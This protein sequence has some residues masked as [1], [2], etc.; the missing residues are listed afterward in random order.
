MVYLS[1]TQAEHAKMRPW[2][3]IGNT[4]SELRDDFMFVDGRMEWTRA[5]PYNEGLLKIMNEAIDNAIDNTMVSDNPT[6]VI[7]VK[8]TATHF[9]VENNG[10][11]IPCTP[12][13]GREGKLIPEVIFGECLAGSHFDDERNSIGANGLGI[14]QASIF[15]DEF[16]VVCYDPTLKKLFQCTWVDGMDSIARRTLTSCGRPPA[17]TTVVTFKPT[18]RRFNEAGAAVSLTSL[19][20]LLP[21]VF[22]R[23]AQVASTHPNSK[24]QLYFNGGTVL[25]CRDFKSYMKLFPCKH[26]FY[27]RPDPAVPFEYGISLSSTGQFEHQS[28]VNCQRTT[29]DSSSQTKFVTNKVVGV[30]RDYLLAKHKGSVL[31]RATVMSRLSVFVNCRVQNARFSSQTKVELITKVNFGVDIDP[32][33]VLGVLKKS[34]LLAELEKLLHAK[35]AKE[36]GAAMNGSKRADVS[37]V[38]KYDGAIAAGSARSKSCTLFIVEG[39]SA[40]TMVTTGMSVIG[41]TLYGVF[42]IRGKLLNVRGASDAALKGNVEVVAI[43]K[44]LGLRFDCT[45]ATETEFRTLRYGTL[46]ILTDADADG[47]HITGLLINFILY[48]WPALASKG[49]LE[50]FVTPV[51]KVTKGTAHEHFFNE[52]EYLAWRARTADQA[53]WFVQHL[54]GLGTSE[55]A[56]TL[57]YFKDLPRHTKQFVFSTETT[58]LTD[59]IFN[60]KKAVW[61]KE[62]LSGEPERRALDYSAAS[63]PVDEFYNAELYTYSRMDID[64]SIPCVVDGLKKS[65]RQALCGALHH[66]ERTG[67]TIFKVAQL[68]G[69]AAAHT[70]YAHGEISLQDTLV[71]MAQGFC[72]SNNLALLTPKGAFGSRMLNGK[73]A[74]AARY[75]F[76]SL[77]PA[78]RKL[79]HPADDAVLDLLVEEGQTVQPRFYVPTVPLLLL[80]GAHGIGTGFSSKLPCFKLQDVIRLVRASL[81][82]ANDTEPMPWYTGYDANEL[83]ESDPSKWT[84]YGKYKRIASNKIEITELPVGVSFVKYKEGVLKRLKEN[85]IIYRA[86]ADHVDENTPRF[87][88][89]TIEPLPAAHEDVMRLFQLSS[90][91]TRNCMNFLDTHGAVKSY[92]SI[93]AIVDD[94]L[95][96]KLLYAERRRQSMI[97]ALRAQIADLLQRTT[98]V[99]A[100]VDGRLKVLKVPRAQ[101]CADMRDLHAIPDE[102]HEKFLAISLVSLT[103]ERVLDMRARE[104]LL[105]AKLL[106]LQQ[107]TARGIFQS[108][109]AELE[110]DNKPPNPKRQKLNVVEKSH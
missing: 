109:L 84:F 88:I 41:H 35:G 96:V 44:I 47:H 65:Q 28:F 58:A 73:D 79:M 90:T 95:E 64:R 72:G 57:G 56:D 80:N 102:L 50:R 98:F 43:M 11:H 110:D 71:G 87:S 92:S 99:E 93:A 94:W 1:L 81:N 86:E 51:I 66:F 89:K 106:A 9:T 45:Y 18:L 33:R 25:K 2:L 105:Q 100:V 5:V 20:V 32:G 54:K 48:H 61:R 16:T 108:D 7:R 62:W 13:E 46:C 31:G 37:G 55:R 91:I 52:A 26:T 75:I 85:K 38:E 97:D 8:M 42:P 23:L 104:A 70:K 4:V 10:S 78:T 36:L 49:F 24:L 30:I 12:M 53:K 67:N 69:V 40:K 103:R 27:E 34:G 19:L 22:T 60:P 107:Q 15:S 101:V 77:A 68:A 74:A 59:N 21:W 39:D 3:Y 82:G 83:T 6:T 63:V 29:S 14:K 76:T 17:S